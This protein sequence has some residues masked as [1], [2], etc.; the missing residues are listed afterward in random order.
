MI[1]ELVEQNFRGSEAVSAYFKQLIDK[2]DVFI[3]QFLEHQ[4]QFQNFPEFCNAVTFDKRNHEIDAHGRA[5]IEY[6]SS[7]AVLRLYCNE[8][9]GWIFGEIEQHVPWTGRKCFA[10][11]PKPNSHTDLSPKIFGCYSFG[12][13]FPEA[14]LLAKR[15]IQDLAQGDIREEQLEVRAKL[16]EF[17]RS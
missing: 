12:H 14:Y 10:I 11:N 5:A 8:P 2:L 16:I 6:R 7:I 1:P 15:I 4:K 9:I 3:E 13:K 17:T